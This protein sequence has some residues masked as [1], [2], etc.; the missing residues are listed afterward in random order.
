MITAEAIPSINHRVQHSL[1]IVI[2]ELELYF[3]DFQGIRCGWLVVYAI[4]LE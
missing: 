1:L 2:L 4:L 3:S